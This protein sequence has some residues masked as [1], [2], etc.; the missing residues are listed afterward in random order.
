MLDL[1]SRGRWIETHRRHCV[2]F[3]NNTLYVYPLLSTGSMKRPDMTEKNVD[4]GKESTEIKYLICGSK[5]CLLPY[6]VLCV[7]RKSSRES[8]PIPVFSWWS[9]RK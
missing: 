6:R 3:L 8:A 4:W 9:V 5:H 7:H 1:K 2:V